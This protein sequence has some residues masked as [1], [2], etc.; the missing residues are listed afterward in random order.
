MTHTLDAM[1]DEL[2][3]GGGYASYHIIHTRVVEKGAVDNAS[4]RNVL[5]S[6]STNFFVSYHDVVDCGVG[7]IDAHIL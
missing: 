2:F 7:G 5:E 1:L 4:P 6:V 3:F